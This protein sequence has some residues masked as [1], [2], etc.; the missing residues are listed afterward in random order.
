MIVGQSKG[1]QRARWWSADCRQETGR[2]VNRIVGSRGIRV[3]RTVCRM[4]VVL[5][6]VVMND[7]SCA[8]SLDDALVV[9]H[10]IQD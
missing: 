2:I 4:E 6:P 10:L 8:S 9:P 3:T 7:Q 5:L 1:R